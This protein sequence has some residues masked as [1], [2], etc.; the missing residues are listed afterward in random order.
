MADLEDHA[1]QRDGRFLF[2]LF[3]SLAVATVAGLWIA[4]HLTSDSTGSCAASL[5]GEAPPPSA[6]TAP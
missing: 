5:F 3:L 1:I 6:T 4:S 2:R